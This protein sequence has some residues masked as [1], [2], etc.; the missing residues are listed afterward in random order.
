MGEFLMKKAFTMLE[1]VFVIVVIGI[2]AAV[3]IPNTRTN[4][5][6]EASIQL[7]SAIRYTQHLGL[8]NDTYDTNTTW[9][10]NRWQIVFSGANNNLYSIMSNNGATLAVDPQNPAKNLQNIELRG[11]S[12]TLGGGCTGESII[13]FDYMG[14]PLVGSLAATTTPYPNGMLLDSNCTIV[15][16]NGDENSTLTIMPETGYVELTHQ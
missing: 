11:V 12:V 9:Y 1:L 6:R 5:V 16:S 13:S 8:V 14:R 7:T 4:P 3:I 10:R 15:L 2:L